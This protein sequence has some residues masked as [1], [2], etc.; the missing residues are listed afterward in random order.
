MRYDKYRQAVGEARLPLALLDE[1]RMMDN[2]ALHL[3][4]AG[5]KNVRLATKSLRCPEVIRRL[6]ALPGVIGL[7][8][9]DAWEGARWAEEGADVLMGYPVVHSK[10]LAR[11]AQAV[12]RGGRVTLMADRPEH[13]ARAAEA[14][15]RAGVTFEVCLDLDV[16]ERLPGLH[17]GVH[18]SSVRDAEGAVR[19][20]RELE[21]YASLKITG[22]MAYEAQI[23]GVGDRVPG[24]RL[25]G[26]V[27][28][29]P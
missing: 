2:A 24:A 25:V 11:L 21:Q 14:G 29:R 5:G 18:R 15:T 9:Y 1:A 27:V 19:F 8:T 4:R 20:A 7:M 17:F 3:G 13:L 16:S 12:Q 6:L 10:G 26:A 22:L 28:E 23:A